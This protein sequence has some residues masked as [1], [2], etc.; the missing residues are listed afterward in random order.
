[1]ENGVSCG[2][3]KKSHPG[4]TGAQL[5]AF[6]SM[7]WQEM[8]L[9]WKTESKENNLSTAP[10]PLCTCLTWQM[11]HPKSP[12][13]S[14]NRLSLCFFLLHLLSFPS[15]TPGIPTGPGLH[16]SSAQLIL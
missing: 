9:G 14:S 1:M 11:E 13:S 2:N 4:Q 15:C 10:L 3:K 8:K 16:R 7:H 5:C 6:P 12:Q